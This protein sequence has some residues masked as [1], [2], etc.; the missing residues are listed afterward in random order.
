MNP[1]ARLSNAI[2][3]LTLFLLYLLT[4][5][6]V[7]T[8]LI[9][10]KLSSVNPSGAVSVIE[11]YPDLCLKTIHPHLF[12]PDIQNLFHDFLDWLCHNPMKSCTTSEQFSP[13]GIYYWRPDDFQDFFC[14]IDGI[15]NGVILLDFHSLLSGFT[16][17]VL[18][19]LF[20]EYCVGWALKVLMTSWSRDWIRNV[21]LCLGANRLLQWLHCWTFRVLGGQR[22]CP[23]SKE[24]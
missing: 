14:N 20:I 18:T 15:F 7:L 19:S 17:I 12:P 3:F 13:A 23:T 22:H 10:I 6:L 21:H 11:F 2:C 1:S 5:P 4:H 24:L 9:F 16:S 8:Q